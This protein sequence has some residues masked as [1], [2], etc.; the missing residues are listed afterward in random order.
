MTV[1]H[2]RYGWACIA[3]C[4]LA[5]G[6]SN[7][8]PE[9]RS[10]RNWAE[11]VTQFGPNGGA[12]VPTQQILTPAGSQVELPGLRPQAIA[13]SPD[14][15]LLITSGLTAE[16]VVLDP[17]IG[18]IKQRVPLPPDSIKIDGS[19]QSARNLRPERGAQLSYT[20]LIFAPDGRHIYLSNVQG[21]V[22]VFDVAEDHQ[23]SGP[24]I[25]LPSSN[26]PQIAARAIFLRASPP[27]PMASVFMS[28]STC[29]IA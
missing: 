22:K 3:S 11:Q 9:E 12:I 25:D 2:R 28:R 1:N 21:S 17:S 16:L 6:C 4:A 27:P 7:N 23:V 14:G 5:I 10:N 26:R 20:G 24:R 29:P 19:M 8:H 18:T 13:L 15:Q